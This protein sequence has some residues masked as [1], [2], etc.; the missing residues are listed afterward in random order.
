SVA[1]PVLAALGGGGFLLAR[2]AGEK[3]VLYDFF[4]Q[5]PKSRRHDD[6]SELRPIIADFGEAQ[7]EFHIGMASMATPGVVKGLFGAHA[8]LG[9]MPMSTI[10]EPARKL[11][12][13]GVVLNSLQ[14][15]IFTIVEKIFTSNDDCLAIFG[16]H[17]NPGQLLGDGEVLKNPEYADVLDVLSRE[18]EGLFYRGEIA[19][20]I[21][22]DSRTGGGHLGLEDLSG[23]ELIRRNPLQLSHGGFGLLTN[24]P[25]STG[26]LLIAFALGLLGDG[27]LGQHV[28]AS[29]SHVGMLAN[30]LDLTNE[31]RMDSGL[32]DGDVSQAADKLLSKQFQD[33]YRDRVS[34]HP[35]ARRGTTHISV[36]DGD[37]NAAALTVSNG[38]GSAYIVPGT[39]VMINNMLGEEDINPLG[40]GQWPQDIR[41]SSMMSPSLLLAP[42]GGITALGSGGSNRI[43]SAVL[44]VVLNLT[45]FKMGLEQAVESPRLHMEGGLLSIEDGFPD[46]S[47]ATLG[48]QF[49]D[50]KVWSER[51][52]FFGGVHAVRYD[53]KTRAL[54][55][56]GD[57]RRGGVSIKV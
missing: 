45:D 46:E 3:P 7:Q 32:T 8:D 31:A 28:F 14:A 9:R 33:L 44:Q 35:R 2:P 5:T 30:V 15:Y 36:I 24:P 23:Y 19:Q 12:T 6:E 25:P 18:G 52:L 10:V 22:D 56:F 57:S 20:T 41:M 38:E 17:E 48:A 47:I 40:L 34:G 21:A 39:G 26:G 37:G 11:A 54:E 29:P 13:D 50:N 43:R 4:A 1:E 53:E 49:P 51:N 27:G 16:S 42:D 55:G